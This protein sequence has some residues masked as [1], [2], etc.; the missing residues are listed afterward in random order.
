MK[1][2]SLKWRIAFLSFFALMLTSQQCLALDVYVD[3]T[4]TA[5]VIGAKTAIEDVHKEQNRK[6]TSI[7]TMNLAISAQLQILHSLED[8]IFSYLQ[9]AQRFVWNLYDVKRCV[10]L[11]AIDIPESISK[12][13]NAIPGHLEGT[14]ITALVSRNATDAVLEISN[15][16]AF[17]NTLAGTGGYVSGYGSDAKFSKVNL[18]NSSQRY[19]VIQKV[20]STLE[21][22]NWRFKMLRTQILFYTWRDLFRH[23]DPQSWSYYINARYIAADVISKID[24]LI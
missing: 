8:S 20:K 14:L 2:K 22:I 15:L 11:A 17:L 4:T 18:L 16:I 10:E 23:F 6:L 13:V 3:P 1:T 21:S 9:N 24:R 19:F 12:A 5:A 7:E